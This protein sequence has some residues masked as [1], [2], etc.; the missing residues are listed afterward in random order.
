MRKAGLEDKNIIIDILA[1]SVKN[2]PR[3]DFLLG[4]SKNTN[5]LRIVLEYL[6][7][8]S[9][10]NGEIYLNDDNT[11]AALWKTSEKEEFTLRSIFTHISLFF[12]MGY[13]STSRILNMDRF[14]KRPNNGRYAHL[15][16]IG[17]LPE[18]RGKGYV[19][20]F[21]NFMVDKMSKPE[22]PIYLETANVKNIG[23]YNKIGFHVFKTIRQDEHLLFCMS[24]NN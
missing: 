4:R 18:G 7:E 5:K 24:K 2:D 23:I 19:K 12:K 11:A 1:K 6:F 3:I 15:Y 16:T 9:F 22:S 13:E 14:I 10:N 17:V 21:I 20:Q 8:E